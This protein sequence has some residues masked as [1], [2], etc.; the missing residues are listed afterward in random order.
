MDIEQIIGTKK[1]VEIKLS[2]Y[3]LTL[4]FESQLNIV[5]CDYCQ[6]KIGDNIVSS[7]H[8][9]KLPQNFGGL[10]T[11]IESQVRRAIFSENKGLRIEFEKFTLEI[12]KPDDDYEYLHI[13]SKDHGMY[14][15]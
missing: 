11:L 14:F 5:I 12:P 15:F 1:I 7:W 2:K 10:I 13:L 4:N 3:T 6:L 9:N 8:Y